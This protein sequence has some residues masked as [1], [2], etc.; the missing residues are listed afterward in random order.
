MG[1]YILPQNLPSSRYNLSGI[2][3]VSDSRGVFTVIFTTHSDPTV[4][5]R[6]LLNLRFPAA[7]PYDLI[8]NLSDDKLAFILGSRAPTLSQ[9]LP[10][11]R[12]KRYGV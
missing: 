11:S 12:L 3:S 10:T 7:G 4:E 5:I 1:D 2:I 6:R 9:V 8:T